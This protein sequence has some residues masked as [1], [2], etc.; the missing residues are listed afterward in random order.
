MSVSINVQLLH[1]ALAT[2]SRRTCTLEQLIAQAPDNDPALLSI[3]AALFSRHSQNV[4]K[5]SVATSHYEA[6]VTLF[7]NT[8]QVASA[9]AA[10]PVPVA[11]APRFAAQPPQPAAAVAAATHVPTVCGRVAGQNI[12]S[13]DATPPRPV[14]P[15]TRSTPTNPAQLDGLSA[16]LFAA[17]Q[18]YIE[19]EAAARIQARQQ[20]ERRAV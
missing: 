14:A 4:L 17:M 11:A 7:R 8:V 18:P 1:D 19:K 20:A 16:Q 9:Q 13:G 10:D 15:P 2:A 5:D 3:L 6:L 12:C